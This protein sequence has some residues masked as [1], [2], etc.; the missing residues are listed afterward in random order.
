MGEQAKELAAGEPKK[1]A[2]LEVSDDEPDPIPDA[3]VLVSGPA[4]VRA[5][6]ARSR[7][8]RLHTLHVLHI[9]S[10]HSTKHGATMLDFV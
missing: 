2:N 6:S 10:A 8:L 7:G 1:S 4:F 3:V 5:S 9:L